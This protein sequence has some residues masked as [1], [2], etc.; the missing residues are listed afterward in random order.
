ME[1]NPNYLLPLL[2]YGGRQKL[3]SAVARIY[4]KTQTI[5]CYY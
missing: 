2:G 4:G 5:F 1:E 3:L